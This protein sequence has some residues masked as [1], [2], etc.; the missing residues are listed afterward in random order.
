MTKQ[1]IIDRLVQ[2]TGINKRQI[3]HII[4]NFIDHIIASC[5]RGDR[6]EIRGFGTFCRASRKERNV[7]SP[8]AGKHIK[9]PAKSIISFKA[10]KTTEEVIE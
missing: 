5:D 1:E 7:F 4:D 8:I 2:Q 3:S 6:V 9:L 10:S